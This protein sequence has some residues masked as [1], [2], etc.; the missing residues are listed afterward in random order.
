[1][2]AGEGETV[3][4]PALDGLNARKGVVITAA[5]A[6][7]EREGPGCTV[8]PGD[9]RAAIDGAHRARASIGRQ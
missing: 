3:P 2:S 9:F 7:I 6:A 5:S 8:T 1:V 4:R